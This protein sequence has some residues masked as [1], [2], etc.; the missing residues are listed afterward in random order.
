V[1]LTTL[2]P[3]LYEARAVSAAPVCNDR[4]ETT[5]RSASDLCQESPI[6]TDRRRRYTVITKAKPSTNTPSQS[7]IMKPVERFVFAAAIPLAVINILVALSANDQGIYE[8]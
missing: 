8:R 7:N 5:S 3:P 4:L 2:G 1:L 6:R